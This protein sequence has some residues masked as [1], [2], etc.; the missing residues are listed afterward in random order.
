MARCTAIGMLVGPGM[1]RPG[2]P[3][4]GYLPFLSIF[5]CKPEP[6]RFSAVDGETLAKGDGAFLDVCFHRLVLVC[7]IGRQ[8]ILDLGNHVADLLK[9]GDA[10]PAGGYRRRAEAN[11]RSDRRLFRVIGD[12]VLVAGDV[13]PAKRKLGVLAGDPLR[14]K[15]DQEHM[16]VGAA[17]DEIE[18]FGLH[19]HSAVRWQIAQAIE[20]SAA[21]LLQAKA[22]ESVDALKH[23]VVVLEADEHPDIQMNAAAVAHVIQDLERGE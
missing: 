23:A 9:F 19:D 1:N 12:A 8:T 20:K 4:I 17:G 7:P 16:G 13:G 3:D 6:A 21:N 15:I 14:P 5:C 18:A 11:A 2:L 22:V 10:E